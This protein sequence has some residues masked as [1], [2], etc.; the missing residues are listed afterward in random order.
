MVT[1][2]K[3]SDKW[4]NNSWALHHDNAPAHASLVWQF[5]ASINM[6]V[7]PH[8]PYSLDLTPCDVFLFPK[9][10]LKLKGQCFDSIKEIHA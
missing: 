9:M 8:P 3:R 4:C 10:K 1:E 5:L 6:T 2:E 7:M